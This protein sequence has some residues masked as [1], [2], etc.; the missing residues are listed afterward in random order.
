MERSLPALVALAFVLT[1]FADTGVALYELPRA[2]VAALLIALVIQGIAIALTRRAGRGSWVATTIIACAIDV[3]FAAVAAG[4]LLGDLYAR[5]TARGIDIGRVVVVFVLVMSLLSVGR[6]TTSEAFAIG[7]LIRP[8]RP[9]G[10]PIATDPDI[11]LILLDGYPRSDTL[12]GFGYDNAWFEEALARRGFGLAQQAHSN[13]DYTALVLASMFNMR[14]IGEIPSLTPRPISNVAQN[15]ALGSAI[16]HNPVLN[17][18]EQRGYL[19]AS[20]G[21]P[22][23]AGALWAVDDHVDD[24]TMRLWDRQ[25]LRRTALW[26]ILQDLIVL[27]QH[28][29]LIRNTFSSI[30]EVAEQQQSEHLFL[31]AHVMSPHTP[32]VFAADGEPSSVRCGEGCT[33]LFSIDASTTRLSMTAFEEA[34]AEQVHYLNGLVLAAVDRVIAASPDAAIVIFSDHGARHSAEPAAEWFETFFAA[35][36]PGHPALFA[37]D[38]RPIEMFPRLFGAYFGMDFAVPDDRSYDSEHGVVLPLVLNPWPSQ[39]S[40]APQ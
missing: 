16:N 30:G 11:V 27:P 18:L 1:V 31:F 15:R 8:Q 9:A 5:R 10:Q 6:A 22:E 17:L 7:D 26:P 25:V 37:A 24:G 36:T 35:R 23:A 33:S 13:Y 2:L 34:Y 20:V 28:R 3:R 39:R 14:H 40:V 21:L 32:L 4:L 19:S 38:A 12:T 29:D